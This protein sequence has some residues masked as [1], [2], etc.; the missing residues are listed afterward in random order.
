MTLACKIN[1]IDLHVLPLAY[2]QILEF[3]PKCGIQK[4]KFL[5]KVL[6]R[7]A[8]LR[9]KQNSVLYI[10]HGAMPCQNK[11]ISP[12]GSFHFIESDTAKSSSVCQNCMT[13]V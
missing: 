4:I 5:S 3:G 11:W 10:P 1:F 8:V 13:L 6:P 9:L 7:V 12:Q 2:I